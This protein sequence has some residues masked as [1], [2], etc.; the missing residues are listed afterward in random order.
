MPPRVSAV[1]AELGVEAS[2]GEF[3]AVESLLG[4]S[5]S[6]LGDA[7]GEPGCKFRFWHTFRTGFGVLR[8]GRMLLLGP[9]KSFPTARQLE[10]SKLTPCT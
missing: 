8:M 7:R 10:R 4:G 5:F 6:G 9:S 3:A 1:L 2:L